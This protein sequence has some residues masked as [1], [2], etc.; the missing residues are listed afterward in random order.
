MRGYALHIRFQ[1]S[2][3]IVIHNKQLILFL[4]KKKAQSTILNDL[5][6]KLK[7]IVNPRSKGF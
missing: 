1:H 3:S 5:K 6:E 2:H 7:K 4:M